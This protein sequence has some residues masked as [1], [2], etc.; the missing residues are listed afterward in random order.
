MRGRWLRGSLTIAAPQRHA[1]CK[2]FHV[3]WHFDFNGPMISGGV[4]K[5]GLRRPSVSIGLVQGWANMDLSVVFVNGMRRSGKSAIITMM[6]NRLWQRPP[7]Y[8]RLVPT[9][10][11]K[12]PP[13]SPRPQSPARCGVASARWIEYNPARAFETLPEA[14]SDI[15]KQDA[16]G[17]VVIEADADEHLRFAYPY[18]HRIMVMPLPPT[19]EEVFRDPARAADE[20]RRV[21]DDTASFA[22]EIFGLFTQGGTED[23]EPAE[24]RPPLTATQMRGFLSSPFG[25]ELATRIQLRPPYHGLVESDVIVVSTSAGRAGYGTAECLRRIQQ[26]LDRLQ[27]L[28]N[29]RTELFLCD[30]RD[31]AGKVGERLLKA[32]EPMCCDDD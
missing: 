21:L 12:F 28:S 3:S 23:A 9:N 20:L 2:T 26:L 16:H 32:L 18:D 24:E 30:P 25:D 5:R 4:Q 17:S 27:M 13:R 29:R 1:I 22:S 15:Q 10:S 31:C 14:L 19:V 8:V 11:G 7:H 6:V